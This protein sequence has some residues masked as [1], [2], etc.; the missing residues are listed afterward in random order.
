MYAH[1]IKPVQ[2]I[3]RTT[4]EQTR[5]AIKQYYDWWLTPQPDIEIGALVMLNATNI[6]NKRPTRNFIPRW[7]SP[8][9]LLENKGNRAFKLDISA[10]WKIHP[11]FHLVRLEPYK[12]SDRPNWEQPPQEPAHLEGDIN[13]EVERIILSSIITYTRKVRRVNREFKELRYFVKWA[14]CSEDENTGEPP[15]GL[16]NA[17]EVVETFHRKNTEMSLPNLAE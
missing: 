5:E 1:W 15:E 13:W 9:N 4:L 10:R 11:V 16:E 6:K 12:V 17:R 8:F 7:Y 2:E 14:G 3:A